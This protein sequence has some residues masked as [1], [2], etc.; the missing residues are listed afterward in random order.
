MRG[1]GSACRGLSSARVGVLCVW[2]CCVAGDG[3]EVSVGLCAAC[4]YVCYKRAPR[5]AGVRVPPNPLPFLLQMALDDKDNW[6][7]RTTW[8]KFHPKSP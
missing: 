1:L 2:L 7:F 4:V 8:C 3:C 6:S 5:L